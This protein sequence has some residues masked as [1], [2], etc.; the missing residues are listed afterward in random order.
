MA[1][2][3]IF[4]ANKARK[5]HNYRGHGA[6][7]GDINPGNGFRSEEAKERS[8]A[9]KVASTF[10]KLTLLGGLIAGPVLYFNYNPKHWE[11]VKTK[12]VEILEEDNKRIKDRYGSVYGESE[13]KQD[14]KY[15]PRGAPVPGTQHETPKL[16]PIQTGL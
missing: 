16:P 12:A 2:K 15:M 1:R 4:D 5:E 14:R 11:A 7:D 10:M 13:E 6:V 3:N 8:L 9:G